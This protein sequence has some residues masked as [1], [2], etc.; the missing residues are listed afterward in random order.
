M[1]LSEDKIIKISNKRKLPVKITRIVRIKDMLKERYVNSIR[2]CGAYIVITRNKE[3]YAGSTE[4]FFQRMQ[5]HANSTIKGRIPMSAY[6]FETKSE[7]D[8]KVLERWLIRMFNPSLNVSLRSKYDHLNEKE[9]SSLCKRVE[10]G[11]VRRHGLYDM[12][13]NIQIKEILS[14]L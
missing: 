1:K 2:L 10:H 13:K 9:I 5:H 7:D 4:D 3:N 6:L 8:A 14:N 11:Y 12:I